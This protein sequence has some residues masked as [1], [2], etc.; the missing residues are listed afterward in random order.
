MDDIALK[1]G[2]SHETLQK[3]VA[4][5]TE[6]VEK[7]LDFERENFKSI[8][9]KHDFEGVNA[10]DILM[11]VSR[12]TSHRFE[13]LTPSLTHELKEDF[14]AIYQ[15]HLTKRIEFIFM[16]IQINL[17]KGIN[18]GMYRPDLSIELVA[19]M[20][21]ARL[22][23]IHNPDFFPPDKFSFATLFEEMFESFIRSVTTPDG[24]E[25]Y[26]KRRKHLRF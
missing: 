14:P 24:I 5:K 10:I 21:I 20:Y 15:K 16:K 13:K 25:Y 8:F 6:L 3:Y 26:E 17:T 2:V 11:T 7:A 22:M 4:N 19:R 9:D 12:E 1:I 23:D 18:Q